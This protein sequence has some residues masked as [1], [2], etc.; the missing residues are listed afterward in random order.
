VW[1]VGR[2]KETRVRG[3]PDVSFCPVFLSLLFGFSFLCCPA[4]S[5]PCLS[6]S[7]QTLVRPNG[8]QWA[9]ARTSTSYTSHMPSSL[10]IPLPPSK[11]TTHHPQRHNPLR[12]RPKPTHL[13]LPNPPP[14]NKPTANPHPANP[15]ARLRHKLPRRPLFHN[16]QPAAL[17]I[18][19]PTANAQRRRRLLR[20]AELA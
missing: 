9:L 16:H 13:N 19:A 7:C 11:L 1:V 2:D 20:L 3:E 4:T 6:H 18:H 17:R 5:L 8:A 15:P 10:P 14:H 12:R